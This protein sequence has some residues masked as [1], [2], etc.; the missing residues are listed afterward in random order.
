MKAAFL[1]LVDPCVP[2]S[3]S[4]IPLAMCQ[5]LEQS[6]VRLSRMPAPPSPLKSIRGR[7]ASHIAKWRQYVSVR[8]SKKRYLYEYDPGVLSS[9]WRFARDVIDRSTA[10][11]FVTCDPLL[12]AGLKSSRPIVLWHDATFANLVNFYPHFTNLASKTLKDGHR[13]QKR[14]LENCRYA[15]YSSEW[16]ANSAHRDYGMPRARIKV[17]PFG[18]TISRSPSR[19]EA[20]QNVARRSADE[21]S[22]LLVGRGWGRKG[23]DKAVAVT[24]ELNRS[25]IRAKLTIVGSSPPS[26]LVLP[27]FVRLIPGLSKSIAAQEDELITLYETS[28]F[29]IL[30]T[31]ADC[32]PIVFSEANSFGVPVLATNVGGISSV[33]V[34]GRNGWLFDKAAPPSEFVARLNGYRDEPATY[35]EIAMNSWAEADSR[36]NWMT[37][38]NLV[39]DL[40]R[41]AE[42][43]LR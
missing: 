12:A 26:D 35:F 43:S 11:V 7:V 41:P 38:A 34:N 6:G 23:C 19:L 28:H 36:L 2:S 1:S 18:G 31:I 15:L 27:P 42:P 22:L 14:A 25:G 29:L 13:L 8:M 40:L 30:P 20:E 17:A 5:A 10:D 39:R 32:T 33:I 9:A 21:L 37:G 24:D 16:A 4:G 3:W